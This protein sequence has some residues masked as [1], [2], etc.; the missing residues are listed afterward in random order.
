MGVIAEMADDVVVMYLG[1]DVERGPVDAIFHE[2]AHPYTRSLLRS[3]PSVLAEPR[4]RLPTIERLDPASLQPAAG[5]PL[6]PALPRLRSPA[7]ATA[8]CRPRSALGARHEASCFLYGADRDPSTR[9]RRA[10]LER[11]G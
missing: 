10:C 6:P 5:L 7:S 11:T 2:P 9:R 8:A 3:I 1:R 4:S